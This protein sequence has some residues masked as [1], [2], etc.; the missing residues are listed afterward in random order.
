MLSCQ[1]ILAEERL[2]RAGAFTYDVLLS[3]RSPLVLLF[4]TMRGLFEFLCT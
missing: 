3:Q 4:E 1:G 2:R